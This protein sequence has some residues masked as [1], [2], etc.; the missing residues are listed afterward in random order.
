MIRHLQKFLSLLTIV[1]A[2]SFSWGSAQNTSS[3]K[4]LLTFEFDTASNHSQLHANAIGVINQTART[5]SITVP[6]TTDIT[7][8]KATFTSSEFSKVFFGIN[9]AIGVL[10]TSNVTPWN[11]TNPVTLTVQAE[12]LSYENYVVTVM[13][14]PPSTA[15][16]ML[17]F[18][19]KWLKHWAGTCTPNGVFSQV[20]PDIIAGNNVI[21][22]VPFGTKLDSIIVHFT[23]SPFATCNITDSIQNFDTDHNGVPEAKVFTITSQSGVIHNYNVLPVVGQAN[24]DDNLLSFI[25]PNSLTPAVVNYNTHNITAVVANSTTFIAPMWAIST[26]AHMFSDAQMTNEI[27]PGTIFSLTGES[28]EFHFWIQAELKSDVSEF[29]LTVTKTVA[30]KICIL[31]AIDANYTKHNL[32][33]ENY[34]GNIVGIIGSN[35]VNFNVPYG[36]NSVTINHEIFSPWASTSD[37]VG[38]VLNTVN[39]TIVITAE[40]G[41]TTKT[42]NVFITPGAISNQ[43]QLLTFGFNRNANTGFGFTWPD[44]TYAGTIDQTFKR[45]NVTVPYNTNLYQ[46]K[47]YF[48][49]SIYSCISI[50]ESNGTFTPQASELNINNYSNIL[51]YVVTAEDG[52]QERYEVIIAKTPAKTGNDLLNLQISLFDCFD[53]KYI[54]DGTYSDNNIILV[55]V[56]Y[57]TVLDS[58]STFFTISDGATVTPAA[59][60]IN[61]NNPVIFTVTSQAGVAKKYTVVALQRAENA[62]KKL[63]SFWFDKD[64]NNVFDSNIIGVI[65]ETS[66]TVELTIPWNAHASIRNLKASFTLSN[67]AIMKHENVLQ[68]SGVNAYDYI[69]PIVFKV[70]AENCSTV[71]YFVNVTVISP[72][73]GDICENAVSLTLPVVNHFGTTIG[74]SDDYNVSP[75]VSALNYMSGN[76]KVYTI[77]LPYEGYLTGSILGNYGSIHVLD[78][79]PTKALDASHCKAFAGGPNGGQFDVKIDAGT[80]LVIISTWSPPQTLDYLLNMSFS[81]TGINDNVLENKLNIYPNPANDRFTVSINNIKPIDMTIQLVNISGQVIYRNELKNIQIQNVEIDA[82]NFAKGVYY[83]RINDGTNI[84]VVKVIIQ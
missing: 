22:S 83:L 64:I 56:K 38:T 69:T 44:S 20:E 28:N 74:Y 80:Y 2:L 63:L 59:G 26:Y 52:T 51:T 17:A 76:D 32:C 73:P 18:S 7:A 30:S 8:L 23:I 19:G 84:K 11:Y 46:L 67:G 78:T 42:Y 43:K 34:T 65:N 62:D 66:K 9:P 49:Q 68:E 57:G 21:F 29:I 72:L 39:N 55:S 13:A 41:I 12:N 71:E 1:L 25:V 6:Y 5:V 58:I 37:T 33:G 3:A 53:A 54:V 16:N 10:A 40:D 24:V 36:V 70:W 4:Q 27:C 47:A 75:C 77:T 79:C 45:I 60:I 50:A 81:G 82:S 14:T 15:N 35:F 48:T 61:F 31:T